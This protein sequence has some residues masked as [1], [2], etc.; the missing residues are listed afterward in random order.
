MQHLCMT[1]KIGNSYA[2]YLQGEAYNAHRAF[3]DVSA[4]TKLFMTTPLALV[5]SL[6]V[7]TIKTVNCVMS[8]YVTRLAK[9]S[10]IAF[11]IAHV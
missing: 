9:R 3:G 1:M 8:R 6:S 11:P 7:L 2:K 10:L 5:L 4:I